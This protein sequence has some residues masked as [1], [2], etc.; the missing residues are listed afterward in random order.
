MTGGNE[1]A[2]SNEVART[3]VDTTAPSTPTRFVGSLSGLTVRLTWTGSPT[4]WA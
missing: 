2:K 3:L 4:T 1:S